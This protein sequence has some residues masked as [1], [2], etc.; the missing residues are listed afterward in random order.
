VYLEFDDCQVVVQTPIAWGEMDAYQ[1]VNNAVYFRY[2]E[3]ARMAYFDQTGVS[4]LKESSGIGP[5]L[6]S[7]Q[8]RYKAPLAYPDTVSIAAGVSL[9]SEDRFTMKYFVK[10]H[11]SGRVVAVGEGEIVFYDYQKQCK[12]VIPDVI[13][14]RIIELDNL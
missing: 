14:E 6:A 12:H 10:S 2:F 1:H 11:N 5:I 9:I 7:T 8:C 13:R 3:T 4:S